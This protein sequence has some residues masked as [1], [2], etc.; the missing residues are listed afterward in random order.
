MRENLFFLYKCN[1]ILIVDK[2]SNLTFQNIFFC[3]NVNNKYFY[4]YS[5][6]AFLP[7]IITS[8]ATTAAYGDDGE[9]ALATGACGGIVKNRLPD[10]EVQFTLSWDWERREFAP[11]TSNMSEGR[12]RDHAQGGPGV[13][14]PEQQLCR[15]PGG[16]MRRV[17]GQGLRRGGRWLLRV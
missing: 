15:V 13:Q 12:S 8:L 1:F 6:R 4:K 17:R 10:A 16:G 3:F 14:C 7:V 11:N 2:T 5:A 9:G